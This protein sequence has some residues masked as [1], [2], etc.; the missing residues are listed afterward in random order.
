MEGVV[1][2]TLGFLLLFAYMYGNHVSVLIL[3]V[4]FVTLHMLH[5][6]VHL[7]QKLLSNGGIILV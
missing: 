1:S 2:A 5:S 4:T 3:I 6:H 7:L